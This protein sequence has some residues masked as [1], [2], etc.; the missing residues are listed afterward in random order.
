MFSHPGPVKPR[1]PP[2]R[3][4]APMIMI[5]ISQNSVVIRKK[6]PAEIESA[7][8][9]YIPAR[10]L[11][12]TEYHEFQ[13]RTRTLHMITPPI[14]HNLNPIP[15][16]HLHHPPPLFLLKPARR[17]LRIVLGADLAFMPRHPV[18][19][20]HSELARSTHNLRIRCSP[21]G[22]SPASTLRI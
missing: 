4:R 7:I 14:L 19:E 11:L 21:C 2:V 1:V 8:L 18:I 9:A 10:W 15:R 5:A 6:P 12:T 3:A 22:N 20:T 16:T 17:L 13:K